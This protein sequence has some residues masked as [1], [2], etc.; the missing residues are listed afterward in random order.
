MKFRLEDSL[1]KTI[2]EF[3]EH[4]KVKLAKLK[5]MKSQHKL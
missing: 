2:P 1:K 3:I 5:E 4:S